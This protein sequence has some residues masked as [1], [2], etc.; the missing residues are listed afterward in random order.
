MKYYSESEIKY[1]I[2][3]IFLDLTEYYYGECKLILFSYLNNS[4]P[5]LKNSKKLVVLK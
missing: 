1:Y 5:K 2:L 3:K 4:K